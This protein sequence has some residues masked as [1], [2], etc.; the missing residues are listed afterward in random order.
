MKSHISCSFLLS[1]GHTWFS[2][3]ALKIAGIL[4]LHLRLVICHVTRYRT[5]QYHFL[6][7]WHETWD[8]SSNERLSFPAIATF[9]FSTELVIQAT[10]APGH[11]RVFTEN[12]IVNHHRVAAKN[13]AGWWTEFAT[14]IGEV[15]NI[16]DA[17]DIWKWFHL[18][19]FTSTSQICADITM[20]TV[21]TSALLTRIMK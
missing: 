9:I 3:D 14:A 8:Y 10:T 4:S 12:G 6:K 15:K 19:C 20:E 5:F 2:W 17:F 1:E 21:A 18:P 13:L 11:A 7:C 16:N